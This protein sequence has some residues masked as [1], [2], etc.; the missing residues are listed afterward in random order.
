MSILCGFGT[1]KSALRK[2]IRL[3]DEENLTKRNI[4]KFPNKVKKRLRTLRA[5]LAYLEQISE[6]TRSYEELLKEL[7]KPE[8]PK[9]YLELIGFLG[10]VLD[11][12]QIVKPGTSRRKKVTEKIRASLERTKHDF[13]L[14]EISE[15]DK[16]AY[17]EELAEAT[18]TFHLLEVVFSVHKTMK[19]SNPIASLRGSMGRRLPEEYFAELLAGW[20]VEDVVKSEL[21][22]KGFE[23]ELTGVDRERKVF[24]KKPK[25]MGAYDLKV[26]TDEG[27][28]FL[29]VQR[30][31]PNKLKQKDGC[32]HTTLKKHKYEGGMGKCKVLVLWVGKGWSK[33]IDK[34]KEGGTISRERRQDNPSYLFFIPNLE[35]NK[36]K[37]NIRY[38][39]DKETLY[40]EKRYL[41]QK[42]LA[43]EKFKEIS[44]EDL[45]K[46][47]TE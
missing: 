31:A 47:F 13:V 10:K 30:I 6:R 41:E 42:A 26:E 20:L 32:F 39:N 28:Y 18:A 38:D 17:E 3:L 29:E 22:K 27:T 7:Q 19:K 24:M 46:M 5:F 33:D 34:D 11:A 15:S 37:G 16:K 12:L 45:I 25:N 36:Y 4:D 9:E 2:C 14:E 1:F 21:K 23:V 40:I 43:Y 35:E 8:T 44:K